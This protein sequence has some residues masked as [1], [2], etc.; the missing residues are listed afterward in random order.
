M[1]ADPVGRRLQPDYIARN[2]NP[3]GEKDK[4]LAAPGGQAESV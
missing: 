1:P 3:V 4:L 2:P